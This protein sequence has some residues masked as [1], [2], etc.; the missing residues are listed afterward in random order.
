[1]AIFDAEIVG[2][3]TVIRSHYISCERNCGYEIMLLQKCADYIGCL[4]L[5]VRLPI[6]LRDIS[7]MPLK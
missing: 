1:M 3:A 5:N 7:Y 2:V 6:A 4:A